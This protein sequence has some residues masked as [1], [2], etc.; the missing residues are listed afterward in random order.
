MISRACKID[1]K[2]VSLGAYAQGL[3][4]EGLGQHVQVHSAAGK[5]APRLDLVHDHPGR[6]EDIV[7][8]LEEVKAGRLEGLVEGC[9]PIPSGLGRHAFQI[10]L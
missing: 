6:G 7:I 5:C 3:Q 4:V 2:F 8:H 9:S 1:E 10:L